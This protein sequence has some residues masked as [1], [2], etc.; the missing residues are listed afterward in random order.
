[1]HLYAYIFMCVD[2]CPFYLHGTLKDKILHEDSN[3]VIISSKCT[4]I[5]KTTR[6]SKAFAT[7]L[8]FLIAN[9][10]YKYNLKT[11]EAVL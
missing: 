6:D 7:L 8:E 11:M 2:C 5:P 9:E 4:F 10:F 1:M 3:S